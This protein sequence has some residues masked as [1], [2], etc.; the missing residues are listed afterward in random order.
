MKGLPKLGTTAGHLEVVN[1][2]GYGRMRNLPS[3][4][5]FVFWNLGGVGE[6]C[7]DQTQTWSDVVVC[8]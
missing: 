4:S 1:V 5:G 8:V 6:L 3:V 2:A 7:A